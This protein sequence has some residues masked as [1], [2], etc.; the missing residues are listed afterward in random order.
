MTRLPIDN[1]QYEYIILYNDE[2]HLD[3]C[4]IKIA[5]KEM[6]FI[7][8]AP[9]SKN[10][11]LDQEDPTNF[12]VLSLIQQVILQYQVQC[13]VQ[14]ITIV[15]ITYTTIILP[16]IQITIKCINQPYQ[17]CI[18]VIQNTRHKPLSRNITPFSGVW[19]ILSTIVN[20]NHN[21]KQSQLL[22]HLK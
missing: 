1:R 4:N 19:E 11:L 18:V 8:L 14:L 2:L 15:P 3:L 10:H 9:S 12:P 21:S 6:D 22:N 13:Q 17:L 5:K 7:T 20:R 16:S